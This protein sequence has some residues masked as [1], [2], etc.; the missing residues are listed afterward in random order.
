MFC[1][2]FKKIGNYI[3]TTLI[4]DLVIDVQERQGLKVPEGLGTITFRRMTRDETV[5]QPSRLPAV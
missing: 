3:Y 1:F 4:H 5:C 2:R